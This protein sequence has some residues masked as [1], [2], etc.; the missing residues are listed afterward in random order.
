MSVP[1]DSTLARFR[2]YLDQHPHLRGRIAELERTLSATIDEEKDNLIGIAADAGFDISPWKS[3]PGL[4]EPSAEGG[5][6][7]CGFATWP[8]EPLI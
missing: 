4:T 8:T 7:C 5:D 2:A 1:E 6:G 3:R